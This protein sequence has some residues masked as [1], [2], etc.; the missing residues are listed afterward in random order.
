M[1]K[2][3]TIF[4]TLIFAYII[5]KMMTPQVF[6]QNSPTLDPQ[7]IANVK[8]LPALL[9]KNGNNVILIAGKIING[10]KIGTTPGE[11]VSQSPLLGLS[12]DQIPSGLKFNSFVKGV[13]AAE[14]AA[15]GKKYIKMSAGT[16]YRVSDRT[17]KVV[18]NGVE[19][20]VPIIEIVN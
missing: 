6:I 12:E 7:F 15:T 2:Y 18:V 9:K 4:G 1:K 13:A 17:M 16:Q 10:I 14:D 3:L 20:E 19:K 8:D 11:T 5:V